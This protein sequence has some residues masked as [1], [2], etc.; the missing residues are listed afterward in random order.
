MEKAGGSARATETQKLGQGLHTTHTL[1]QAANW[2]VV[3][4]IQPRDRLSLAYTVFYKSELIDMK[5]G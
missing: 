1:N 2:L 3:T 4:Q 5:V